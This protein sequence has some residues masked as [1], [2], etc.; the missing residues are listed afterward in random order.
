MTWWSFAM[1]RQFNP[2]EVAA[3]DD[4]LK[5][6]GASC[7]FGGDQVVAENYNRLLYRGR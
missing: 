2:P 7:F 4:F 3:L 5:Q 1:S 6:A